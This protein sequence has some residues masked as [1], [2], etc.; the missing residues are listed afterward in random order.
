MSPHEV[1]K[2][3]KDYF[4]NR[5]IF[6]VGNIHGGGEELVELIITDKVPQLL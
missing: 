5:I 4:L 2:I 3:I 6:G 1:Y